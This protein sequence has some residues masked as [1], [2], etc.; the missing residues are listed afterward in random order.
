MSSK[1]NYMVHAI[2]QQGREAY[3]SDKVWALLPKHKNGWVE[4]ADI[5]AGDIPIPH[6]IIEF[7]AKVTEEKKSNINQTAK[8][9]YKSKKV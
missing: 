9:T 3:F 8:R 4:F 5:K 2:N 1:I 6:Q 7:Q